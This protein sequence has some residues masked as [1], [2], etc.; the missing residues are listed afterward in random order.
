MG[1]LTTGGLNFDAKVRRQS[2]D[3]M[4]LFYAHIGG[5]DAFARG[6]EIAYAIKEDGR[7]QARSSRIATQGWT[8][9]FGADVLAGRAHLGTGRRA[10]PRTRANQRASRAGRRCWRT[11]STSS[12][13][14]VA[15]VSVPANR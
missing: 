1:G 9:G 14:D 13:S 10:R 8:S 6:L 7:L 3:E 11:S 2:H 15:L 4:D 12:R 5:M